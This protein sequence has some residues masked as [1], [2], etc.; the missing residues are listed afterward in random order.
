MGLL[1][2]ALHGASTPTPL[3]AAEG[4]GFFAKARASRS[5]LSTAFPPGREETAGPPLAEA[6][7]EPTLRSL[8]SLRTDLL[9]TPVKQDYMLCVFDKFRALPVFQGLALLLPGDDGFRLAAARGFMKASDSALP[10]SLFASARRPGDQADPKLL[11]AL[12]AVLGLEDGDSL[13]AVLVRGGPQQA[14]TALWAYD[15]GEASL[16]PETHSAIASGLLASSA[17]AE[18]M[19][20]LARTPSD[21]VPALMRAI[22]PDRYAVAMLFYL[23]KFAA[24]AKEAYPGLRDRAAICL[25][26]EAASRILGFQGKAVPLPALRMALILTSSSSLDAELAMFQVRRSLSRAFL[27]LGGTDLFGGESFSF[28]PAEGDSVEALGRFI[29]G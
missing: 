13:R 19:P 17:R 29:S 24:A 8:A 20:S 1:D 9:R 18:R 22:P 2:R 21:L 14:V 12:A 11:S 4:S 23:P 5:S 10:L 6:P 26:V 16:A 3:P 27:F 28:D 7:D 25:A 15:A